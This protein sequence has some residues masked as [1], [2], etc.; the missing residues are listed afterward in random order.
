MPDTNLESQITSAVAQ[1]ANIPAADLQNVPAVPSFLKTLLHDYSQ[2]LLTAGSVWLL[3]HGANNFTNQSS[4][5]QFELGVLGLLVSCAW[6]LVI[7]YLRKQKMTTL[8][9]FIPVEK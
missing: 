9:N 1:V 2:K 7:A 4:I 5:E 6:T 3:T 8:L